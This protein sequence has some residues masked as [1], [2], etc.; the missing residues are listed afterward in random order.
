M[1]TYYARARKILIDNRAFLEGLAKRL[2]EKDTLV[3]SEIKEIKEKSG[4]GI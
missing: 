2:H 3:S 1:E 4:V